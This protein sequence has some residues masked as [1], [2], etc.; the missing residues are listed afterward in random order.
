MKQA[1]KPQLAPAIPTKESTFPA[2]ELP[3]SKGY[4]APFIFPPLIICLA[5]VT[6]IECPIMSTFVAPV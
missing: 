4:G 1:V 5:K 2:R 3:R 6:P